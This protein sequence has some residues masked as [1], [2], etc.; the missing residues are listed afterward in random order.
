[1][2]SCRQKSEA[3]AAMVGYS[4]LLKKWEKRESHGDKLL[5]DANSYMGSD[6]PVLFEGGIKVSQFI[7]LPIISLQ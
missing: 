3:F 1:M 7:Q 2:R 5:Q 4:D 6:C